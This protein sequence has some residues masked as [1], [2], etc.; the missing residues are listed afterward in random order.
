MRDWKYSW[1]D[2]ARSSSEAGAA[3]G[4][5]PQMSWSKGSI[6]LENLTEFFF[7]SLLWSGMPFQSD[8]SRG[9]C[10]S[11]RVVVVAISSLRPLNKVQRRTEKNVH[12]QD[13]SATLPPCG[14]RQ[15]QALEKKKK[16]RWCEKIVEKKKTWKKT[17]RRKEKR[18]K[19]EEEEK[20][21]SKRP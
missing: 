7:L 14:T 3:E 13:R 12:C 21:G 19:R 8:F 1:P 2:L 4:L 18:K 11:V 16:K 5:Q 15:R 20:R 9:R 17:K 10:A 6:L